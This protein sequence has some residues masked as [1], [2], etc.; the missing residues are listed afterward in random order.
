M[1]LSKLL[2]GNKVQHR[3]KPKVKNRLQKLVKKHFF[4]KGKNKLDLVFVTKLA[5]LQEQF[6]YIFQNGNLGEKY[7]RLKTNMW[8]NEYLR[9][10]RGKLQDLNVEFDINFEKSQLGL[11][12]FGALFND[13]VLKMRFYKQ[14]K[15]FVHID[16]TET[17][18][19]KI[20]NQ[21]YF[22]TCAKQQ[23]A[24]LPAFARLYGHC[25][26]LTECRVSA[27]M[28][29]ALGEYLNA[30]KYHPQKIT[31]Q[32]FIDDCGMTD[33]SFAQILQG[34]EN[35]G[36]KIKQIV[37]SNNDM[38][39]KSVDVLLRLI[40]HLRELN[41]NNITRSY[42]KPMFN[43]IVER[44]LTSGVQLQRLKLS[45]VNLNDNQIVHNLC[46]LLQQRPFLISLDVSWARLSSKQLDQIMGVLAEK[47]EHT[48][49]NL[50]I[51][52]NSLT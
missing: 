31:K 32:L 49:R 41:F 22:K 23:E 36:T 18:K 1:D 27:T 17:D 26:F 16:E 20:A 6:E 21:N 48:L 24:P 2:F 38:S 15:D 35:Q 37:Y 46:D 3:K 34:L 19:E 43:Q 5:R 44:C 52:Y 28:A 30:T 13:E 10:V 4:N 8:A 9:D 12:N 29:Q 50:N 42:G 14:A 45:N 39:Y 7:D 51:S 25:L 33:G 11:M 40:P 47:N